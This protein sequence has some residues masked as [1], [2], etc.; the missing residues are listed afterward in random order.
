MS[1]TVDRDQAFLDGVRRSPM[2]SPRQTPTR[3]TATRAFPS[4]RSTALREQQALSAFVPTELGGGGVSFEALAGACFELGQRCGASAM[5]FAMHQIQVA[6]IVRH[7]DGAPWFEDYLR[8]RRRR[9]AADR[10]GDLR[11]RHRR[12]HGTLDRQRRTGR[13]WRLAASRSRRRPSATAPTPTICS[14]PCA[15]RPKPSPATRSAC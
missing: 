14:R 13:R 15:A 9:T 2:R 7:L 12:R 11:G 10:L 5:V 8:E 3:S 1:V 4:R 6:T